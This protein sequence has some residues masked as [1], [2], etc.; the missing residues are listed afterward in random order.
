MPAHQVDLGLPAIISLPNEPLGFL[1]TAP[2]LPCALERDSGFGIPGHPAVPWGGGDRFSTSSG[3]WAG[4][5]PLGCGRTNFGAIRQFFR[6]ARGATGKTP[7]HGQAGA[8]S[9]AATAQ[10]RA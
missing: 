3:L 6:R 8:L 10:V 7:V 1:L 4:K 9:P 2:R 5:C